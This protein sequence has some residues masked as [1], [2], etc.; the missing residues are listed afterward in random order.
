MKKC[1]SCTHEYLD[2]ISRCPKCGSRESSQITKADSIIDPVVSRPSNY[3][4]RTL[5]DPKK[6]GIVG[7]LHNL[8]SSKRLI[9]PGIIEPIDNLTIH[10]HL[11]NERIIEIWN[12]AVIRT[13]T[14]KKLCSIELVL[15][16]HGIGS[17][18]N[19]IVPELSK[20]V[21]YIIE[22]NPGFLCFL[23][24]STL[25]IFLRCLL[26][27]IYSHNVDGIVNIA[28]DR[29]K[30]EDFYYDHQLTGAATT[31]LVERLNETIIEPILYEMRKNLFYALK[32]KQYGIDYEIKLL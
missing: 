2:T 8:F 4:N 23:A 13:V 18:Q 20:M 31:L 17:Q 19:T 5:V 29:K 7:F 3:P 30:I 1:L 10:I 25:L 14:T 24:P 9:L 16:G 21:K 12:K 22:K 26:P 28:S 15:A 27:E 6:G 11:I 32:G